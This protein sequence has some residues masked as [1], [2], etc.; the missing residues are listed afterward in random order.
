MRSEQ[1]T[2][3]DV[4]K[5]LADPSSA[6][7]ADL[8]GKLGSNFAN[9]ALTERE[10][11]LATEILRVIA[12]D[13]EQRVR[14][15]LARSICQS[16]DLPPDVARQLANDIASVAIP[17]LSACDVLT[18]EDLIAIV[19]SRATEHRQ[20]IAGRATVSSRVVAS[21]VDSGDTEAVSR[22]MA[23]EG[24]AL[25]EAMIER[26]LHRY[27]RERRVTVPLAERESLPLSVAERLVTLISD[28]LRD[29]LIDSQALS[30]DQAMNLLTSAR[31]QSTWL[32]IEGNTESLDVFGLVDQLHTAGQLTPTLVLRAIC[33]GDLTF[34]APA[35][36]KRTGISVATIHALV[37]GTDEVRRRKL[38][39]RAGLSE[40]D[41][42]LAL[43]ALATRIEL[44]ATHGASGEA[45]V[46]AL[47]PERLAT[48]YETGLTGAQREILIDLSGSGD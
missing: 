13:V 45:A 19:E 7:R 8:A 2:R 39:I 42:G 28:K 32:L 34:A 25:D 38:L 26:V 44:E 15:A 35:L 31:E 14:E 9:G 5:L 1:L 4:T 40:E 27:G 6:T 16:P 37:H 36:A 23:N 48:L 20:A 47:L 29:A 33:A 12:R 30:H 46:R 22:L 21:L 41:V 43:V 17:V 11:E 10:R 18:D 3:E 24:A